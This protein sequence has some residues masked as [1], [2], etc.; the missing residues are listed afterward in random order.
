MV[1]YVKHV[2]K[3]EGSPLWQKG[4]EGCSSSRTSQACGLAHGLKRGRTTRIPK[5]SHMVP[6]AV[7]KGRAVTDD[8]I[9]LYLS[10]ASKL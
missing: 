2:F 8:L 6:A 4:G 9:A 10:S 3:W 5:P 1:L 7:R